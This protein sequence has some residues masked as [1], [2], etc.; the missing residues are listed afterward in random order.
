MFILIDLSPSE[1][2]CVYDVCVCV[3]HIECFR[4]SGW[5]KGLC[6]IGRCTRFMQHRTFFCL[7][8]LALTLIPTYLSYLKLNWWYLFEPQVNRFDFT[9]IHGWAKINLKKPSIITKPDELDGPLGLLWSF[10]NPVALFLILVPSFV[11]HE[12]CYSSLL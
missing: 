5:F 3:N 4:F 6:S 10:S 1:K 7:T 9:V 8:T 12:C 2:T 11:V